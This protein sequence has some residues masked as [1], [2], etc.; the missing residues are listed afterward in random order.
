MLTDIA[1]TINLL[2]LRNLR[3]KNA[4]RVHSSLRTVG[5][6]ISSLM[7]KALF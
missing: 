6:A 5:E 2:D 3:A 4:D 7:Y 1:P